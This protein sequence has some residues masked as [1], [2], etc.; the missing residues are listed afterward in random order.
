MKYITRSLSRILENSPKDKATIIFGPRQVGK[1]TLI[2]HFIEDRD[3]LWLSG[4][5][6]V[7][8]NILTNLPSKKEVL[9]L[10]G[11]HQ[12]IVIDEAQK[13]PGIGL[14]IKR[15]VDA[16]SECKIYVTGS[17]SLDLAGGVYESA[18]GRTRSNYLW[19]FSFE[20]LAS[21]S[22][23]IQ[24]RRDLFSRLV[25]GSYP[26]VVN[27]PS[28]AAVN[29]N[30]LYKN[31]AFKDVL[32]LGGIKNHRAFQHLI[33]VLA[34]RIGQMCSYESIAQECKLSSPTIQSYIT[35][36]EQCFVIKCLP[37]FARNLE[38][39]LKKS[40]KIYFYDLGLRNAILRRFTPFESRSPEEQG[41]LFENYFVIERIKQA[42]YHN[43]MVNHYFWRTKNRAEV[44][45]I[46]TYNDEV[47]AFEIK[48][49]RD[50]VS[51]PPSFRKAY[52]EA[53]FTVVNKNN[54]QDYLRHW[55]WPIIV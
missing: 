12:N 3:S 25:Y 43:C 48:L 21:A 24:E 32:D 29:L 31:I 30:N 26:Q 5:E 53:A 17:S 7:D 54:Y 11:A 14:L 2:E 40:K 33:F 37:S 22:S 1:T 20:E 15:M 44:D 6:P 10:L 16:H 28:Q 9:E 55:D 42:S 41:A 49:S 23:V 52:P 47:Q 35:L 19:P 39:E 8:V 46:E 27:D 36:L 50:D 38:N 51:S 34:S 13:V 45:L 18:A 4:D